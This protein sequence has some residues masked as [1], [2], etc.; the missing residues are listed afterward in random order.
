MTEDP[1]T[2]LK[3]LRS[4]ID[5]IDASLVYLLAE[6]FKAEGQAAARE[7]TLR[8]LVDQYP[9]SRYAERAR[10]ELGLPPPESPREPGSK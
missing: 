2:T 1:T 8:Q 5:N 6:R 10:A 3:R 7:T 4:S 9:T